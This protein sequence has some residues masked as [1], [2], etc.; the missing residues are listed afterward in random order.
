[1][2][3][4]RLPTERIPRWKDWQNCRVS[5]VSRPTSFANEFTE[6]QITDVKRFA[7]EFFAAFAIETLVHGNI[8][9]QVRRAINLLAGADTFAERHR[10]AGCYRAGTRC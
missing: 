9:S 6:I 3:N 5:A 10:F 7:E 8:D 1:M 4:M 2:L